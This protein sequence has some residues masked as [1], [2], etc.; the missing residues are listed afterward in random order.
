MA[1]E[2]VKNPKIAP[3]PATKIAPLLRVLAESDD[4]TDPDEARMP[5]AERVAANLASQDENPNH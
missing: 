4:A 3:L 5:A 2:P 1:T